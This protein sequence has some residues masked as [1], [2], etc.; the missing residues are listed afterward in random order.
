MTEKNDLLSDVEYLAQTLDYQTFQEY[1]CQRSGLFYQNCVKRVWT[2]YEARLNSLT[3]EQIKEDYPFKAFT[4]FKKQEENSDKLVEIFKTKSGTKKE[5]VACA[6]SHWQEIASMF[7]DVSKLAALEAIRD[8]AQR[9]DY[10]I[11]V[12]AQFVF[13]PTSFLASQFSSLRQS[14][15][16]SHKTLVLLNAQTMTDADLLLTSSVSPFDRLIMTGILSA[17][18]E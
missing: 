6:Q 1:S 14:L 5:L 16:F 4:T 8:E 2:E 13:C 18:C 12:H 17:G 10:V 9:V 7:G 15:A 11:N 3:V